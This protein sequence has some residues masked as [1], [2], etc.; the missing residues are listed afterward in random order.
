MKTF[1]YLESR[2]KSI[3]YEPVCILITVDLWTT[4]W[5]G[6]PTLCA[7]ENLS[8]I[9]GWISVSIVPVHLQFLHT[10][11]STAMIQPT[12]DH[13]SCSTVVFTTEKKNKKLHVSRPM[14]FIPMLFKDPLYWYASL[15]AFFFLIL[16]IYGICE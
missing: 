3:T 2:M 15:L 1:G 8:I 16:L 12:S 7:V 14:R 5:L 10:L 13:R 11:S 9:Y 6:V 4:W